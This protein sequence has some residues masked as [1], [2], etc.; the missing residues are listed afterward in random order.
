MTTKRIIYARPQG[1]KW[2]EG[3][4]ICIPARQEDV[5]RTYATTGKPE[6]AEEIA[7]MTEM[8]YVQWIRDRGKDVPPDAIGVKIVDMTEIPTDRT[9]R[10]A[11]QL[12]AGLIKVNMPKA[13]ALHKDRLR[14]LREPMLAALD[15]EYMR[16][17]EDG[18]NQKKAQI[19]A[20]KQSLRDVTTDPRIDAAQT[21]D[22]LKALTIKVLCGL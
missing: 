11:W 12:E 5:V 8:Q 10:D 15:T 18:D 1:H 17:D 3:V 2:G 13:K 14:K 6:L 7:G 20:K 19:R 22:A 9:F 16:A 4:S 21:P